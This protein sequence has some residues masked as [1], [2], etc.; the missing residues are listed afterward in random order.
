MDRKRI[1]SS[2]YRIFSGKLINDTL[3][4]YR[5]VIMLIFL[6][7]GLLCG[8][9]IIRNG[10]GAVLDKLIT[11]IDSYKSVRIQQGIIAN[12]CNS[13]LSG[14]SFLMLSAF[15]GFSAIGAPFIVALPFIRG[16]GLGMICGYL[17]S[18]YKLTGLGYCILIIYP[19]AA[20]AL[21][22]FLLACSESYQLSKSIF[23]TCILTSK[24]TQRQE[25]KDF[26]LKQCIFAAVT[27]GASLVDALMTAI[28]SS[29]FNFG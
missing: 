23:G 24:A 20:V 11:I 17:Y 27:A 18:T 5:A 6:I 1:Y 9:L 8:A 22:A 4:R 21:V 25:I 19:G 2:R 29:F 3:N 10:G 26:L 28:F 12:F 13:M 7:A 16:T 14:M 15:L